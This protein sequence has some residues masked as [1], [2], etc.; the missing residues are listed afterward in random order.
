[1]AQHTTSRLYCTK[2]THVLVRY[3]TQN[4]HNEE[5]TN[6]G[7]AGSEQAVGLFAFNTSH[8]ISSGAKIISAK[9]Y[10][11]IDYASNS[12]TYTFVVRPCA[13]SWTETGVTYNTLPSTSDTSDT[14]SIG[15]ST[16][17]IDITNTF[18]AWF[19]GKYAMANGLYIT[20][21][22]E[23]SRK[24]LRPK[25]Y[26]T[27]DLRPYLQITWEDP[28]SV[29]VAD[30]TTYALGETLRI[31][32]QGAGSGRTH[33]LTYKIGEDVV[34]TVTDVGASDSYALPLDLAN[35][36]TTSTSA[37]MTIVCETFMDGT[38]Q[39]TA[40]TTAGITVPESVK[41]TISSVTAAETVSGWPSTLSGKWVQGVSKPQ[42][43]IT[44][45]G[46][47]GSSIARYSTTL[48][49]QT[50][51]GAA[52]KFGQLSASGNLVATTTV[53][54]TR[55]RTAT[56]SLTLAVLAY[57]PPQISGFQISR[58][59]ESGNYQDSGTYARISA[60]VLIS[61]LEG[62]NTFWARPDYK[63]NGSASWITSGA[64]IADGA[65]SLNI[66]N[67]LLGFGGIFD[68]MT[69]Y[70]FRLYVVDALTTSIAYNELPTRAIVWDVSSSG[71]SIGIGVEAGT[72]GDLPFGLNLKPATDD[73]RAQ[74]MQNLTFL[75]VNPDFE[76]TTVNW[77][78]KG[79]CYAW[80]NKSGVSSVN[81]PPSLYGFL[82]NIPYGPSGNYGEV[83]QIWASQRDG[84]LYHRGG[85]ADGRTEW[86]QI[87]DSAGGTIDGALTASTLT[88]NGSITGYGDLILNVSGSSAF[89][90]VLGRENY[91]VI[92]ARDAD[93]NHRNLY[94]H[95]P[96]N[97]ANTRYAL[98]LDEF[99]DGVWTSYYVPAQTN[100]IELTPADGVTTPGTYGNGVLRY[101]AEGKHVY[102]AGSI[103][104]AW[105]GTNNKLIATLPE[106][107]RPTG[108]YSYFFVPTSGANLSRF[109]V[110]TDGAIY[111]EWKRTLGGSSNTDSGWF[112][113]N[114][115]F[116][117][118]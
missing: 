107:Y 71:R 51:Q 64:K 3:P 21:A 8:G 82:I 28:I 46:A 80:Y 68:E 113:L 106:G 95:N 37:T 61:S 27:E 4:F 49:N 14:V 11:S 109:F 47:Y 66:T 34:R 36:I 76:D 73:A 53:T 19:T 25:G 100:W 50:V 32:I 108:G 62:L 40:S 16:T 54:D 103:N 79:P 110:K 43:T 78:A 70:N 33:T 101:R 55:G 86:K 24:R 90:A 114:M 38:S 99:I 74:S 12:N 7:K 112:D 2:D 117:T 63:A 45:S 5:Y 48:N 26:A 75:G 31:S 69:G 72:D 84:A 56:Y 9:M 96:K 15:N 1:M 97:T 104:A 6:I 83:R 111:L 93:G 23:D 102:V 94:L 35:Y 52:P 116:W 67:Q 89:G 22:T 87:I 44:A 41:P 85:N 29:P 105:D 65:T 77:G 92:R 118:D 91:I 59:D 88:S 115:D 17:S 60:V 98:T 58:C 10:F 20:S 81:N 57:A 30:K 18:N 42:L 13:G 39:G